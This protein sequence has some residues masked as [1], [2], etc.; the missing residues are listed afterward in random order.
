MNFVNNVRNT[1]GIFVWIGII[2]MRKTA[3]RCMMKDV[4][5]QVDEF[6]TQ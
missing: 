3:E 5:A 4:P 6:T 1:Q 2:A